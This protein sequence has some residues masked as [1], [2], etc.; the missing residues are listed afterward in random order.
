MSPGEFA[1]SVLDLEEEVRTLRRAN[2]RLEEEL[3]QYRARDRQTH[4]TNMKEI[5]NI[6][7]L[8]VNKT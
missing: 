4:D 1:L 8:L 6:L 5:G 3:D 7:R 2:A